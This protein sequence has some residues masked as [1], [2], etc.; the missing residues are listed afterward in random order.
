MRD[1]VIRYAQG[2]QTVRLV[3]IDA[4]GM[5]RVVSSATYQIDDLREAELTDRRAVVASTAATLSTVATTITAA[6]GP[7]TANPR[8]VALTSATG[9]RVGGVYLLRDTTG[10]VEEAITVARLVSTSLE[11]T[12]PITRAFA[13]GAAFVGL[14]AEGTFPSIVAADE[15]RLESGGGPFQ[16]TWTYTIGSVVYVQPHE[17]WLTRY[18]FSPWVRPDEI[19]RFLPGLASS[20]GDTV[21]PHE[22]IAA[23][24]EEFAELMAASGRDPVYLRGA[25][26]STLYIC[27]R[28]LVHVCRG[29][30]S[31]ALQLMAETFAGEA[32]AH[33]DNLVIGRPPMRTSVVSHVDNLAAA[34]GE[35]ASAGGYFAPG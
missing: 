22:A 19:Y 8:R 16:V 12:R 6:A 35:K 7:S 17:K 3:P 23:A 10:A 30:R 4:Q 33:A 20:S 21:D 26:S 31:E 34:G 2:A 24:T 14:E 15:T 1:D 18:S 5:P 27:K 11:T 28:A 29:S 13:T 9:V 32:K 25:P